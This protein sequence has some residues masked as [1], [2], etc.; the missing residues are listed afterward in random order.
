MIYSILH[1]AEQMGTEEEVI[2]ALL[3]LLQSKDHLLL[4]GLRSLGY[5]KQV[6]E[7]LAILSLCQY[8]VSYQDY[9]LKLLPYS[10]LAFNVALAYKRN[11]RYE[12]VLREVLTEETIERWKQY[13]AESEESP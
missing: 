13:I 8:T 7:A 11:N 10:P 1:V 6:I 9:V 12:A 5:S 2:V 4:A 3:Y